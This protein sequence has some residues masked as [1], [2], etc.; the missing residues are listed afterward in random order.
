MELGLATVA[1][2]SGHNAWPLRLMYQYSN[3]HEQDK[4]RLDLQDTTVTRKVEGS[5]CHVYLGSWS[6]GR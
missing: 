6:T 3:L 2:P 5:S 1:P 4:G